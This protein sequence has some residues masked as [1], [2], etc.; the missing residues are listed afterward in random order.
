MLHIDFIIFFVHCSQFTYFGTWQTMRFGIT[1]VVRTMPGK[2]ASKFLFQ[3][4]P[5]LDRHG[6]DVSRD[7][8]LQNLVSRDDQLMNGPTP[9][10]GPRE[11]S[12][13]LMQMFATATSED[14][15]GDVLMVP[16]IVK[17]SR[18]SK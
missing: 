10:R 5:A 12:T 8:I 16:R 17:K 4:V 13:L 7:D 11:K 2:P 15:E 14:P 3:P 9:W 1:L 6:V 18:F